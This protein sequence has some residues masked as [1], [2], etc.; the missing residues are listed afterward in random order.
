[1]TRSE[2]RLM[3][4][5]FNDNGTDY[6]VDGFV[7]VYRIRVTEVFVGNFSV[8]QQNLPSALLIIMPFM[9]VCLLDIL[10]AEYVCLAHAWWNHLLTTCLALYSFVSLGD[11]F[12]N[13]AYYCRWGM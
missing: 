12:V 2:P 7:C 10:S 4:C 5:P 3:V 8:R 1:M 13:I 9:T 11:L 6:L